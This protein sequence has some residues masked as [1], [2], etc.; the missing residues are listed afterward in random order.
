ME[1]QQNIAKLMD[2]TTQSVSYQNLTGESNSPVS[3]LACHQ[4][5]ARERHKIRI[6]LLTTKRR[7]VQI[8]HIS[9][10]VFTYKCGYNDF[11]SKYTDINSLHVTQINLLYS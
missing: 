10:F 8:L 4:R 3:L 5:P 9:T 2:S 1:T 11:T 6:A 7:A